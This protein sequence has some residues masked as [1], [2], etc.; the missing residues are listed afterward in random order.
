LAAA[1]N[2]PSVSNIISFPISAKGPNNSDLFIDLAVLGDLPLA[3]KI[4]IHISGTHGVEGSVGSGIQHEFLSNPPLLEADVAIIFIHALNPFGMAWNR[5]V[6]EKNIDL[7]RNCDELRKT[8]E[9]YS[10]LNPILNPEELKKFD[11]EAFQKQVEMHGFPL[12]KKT[13]AEGQ[14]SFPE[15][16]FYGGEEIAEGPR[17]VLDWV[18]NVFCGRN[19]DEL[20]FGILDI[21]SGLGPYAVDTLLT[22]KAPSDRMLKLFGEKMNLSLQMARV[23][24]KATGVFAL[25]LGKRINQVTK[26]ASEQIFI[27]GQEF[28][29]ISEEK[30]L[31]ALYK[32]NNAFHHA[33]RTGEAYDPHGK[34][35]I[36]MLQ[37]FYPQEKLWREQVLQS[38]RSLILQGIELLN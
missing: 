37:A 1:A 19:L 33:K 11:S 3:K 7:N 34:A 10:I 31:L 23:G 9:L 25:E 4:L 36:K 18:E 20:S 14:Y 35:G 12:I 13:L 8:P 26:C 22:P 17:I 5:R 6:N 29:T 21:H 15:G 38:G 27:I 30:M 24:Y 2:N 28:G 32:E 16:L